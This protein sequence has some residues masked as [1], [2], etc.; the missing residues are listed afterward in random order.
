MWH[1]AE[2]Q[3]ASH[4]VTSEDFADPAAVRRRRRGTPAP[5][6][7]DVARVAGVN[8]ST[9]SRALNKPG[10]I[11]AKTEQRIQEA[12]KQLDYRINPMARALPTGRANTIGLMLADITN[13]MFFTIVRGA[14]R[15]AS[16]RGYTLLLAESQES[17]EREAEGAQRLAPSVDALVLVATRLG[18]DQIR[19]LAEWKPLVVVN[20]EVGGVDAIVPE[21]GPGIDEALAHVAALGH[22]SVAYVSGPT[23]SWMNR[24]RWDALLDRAPKLGMTVVEIGPGVPTL[25][26]GRDAV[27]RV[28]ASGVSAVFAYNDLMAIGLMRQIQSQGIDVPGRLSIIGFDDIF[29]SD[30]TSP[31]L[32][33]VR[34]PLGLVGEQAVRR[35]LSLIDED[36]SV[37]V[38]ELTEEP[39]PTELVVRGSTG[40]PLAIG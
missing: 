14:E 30:F 20:R 1:D 28:L 16:E 18:D 26:G 19:D 13:P 24:A 38:A 11:N 15:A 21:V 27:T 22:T 39:L 2:T 34:A 37:P 9:V 12:A 3:E 23:G 6:I 17:G 40:P 36:L 8:P 29:G 10:R 35:A 31:P 4:N 7:Y 25:E 33:T 32:T 5:T